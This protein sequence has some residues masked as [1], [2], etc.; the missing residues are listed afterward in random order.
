M[1][2]CDLPLISAESLLSLNLCQFILPAPTSTHSQKL[3]RDLQECKG[4]TKIFLTKRTINLYHQSSTILRFGS[5]VQTSNIW[6]YTQDFV[7]HKNIFKIVFW[8]LNSNMPPFQHQH[9]DMLAENWVDFIHFEHH[10]CA[11]IFL[12]SSFALLT[13]VQHILDKIE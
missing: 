3:I 2:L 9:V 5:N 6:P 8:S 11:N 7:Y 12:T 1:L 13:S 10:S 4:W